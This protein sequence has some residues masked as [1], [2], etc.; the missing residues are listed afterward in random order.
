MTIYDLLRKFISGGG[1][2]EGDKRAAEQLVDSLESKAALGTTV[3]D[4]NVEKE[5][6]T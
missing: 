3:A 5:P 2:T 4:T 1:W 6:N